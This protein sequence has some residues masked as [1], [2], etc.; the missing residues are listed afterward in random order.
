MWQCFNSGYNTMDQVL[1]E[2]IERVLE[3]I[4]QSLGGAAIRLEK[5][6]NGIVTL[7]YYKPLS[8]LSAC[9]VDRTRANKDIVIEI[10]E[11]E[12]KGMIP[13]FVKVIINGIE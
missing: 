9:H 7:E 4:K 11:E 12:L 5:V 3:R 2:D 13:N 8:N 6:E 10:V 1:S